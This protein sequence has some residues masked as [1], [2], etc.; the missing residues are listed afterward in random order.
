MI[1]VTRDGHVMTLEM[2]REEVLP[3]MVTAFGI[4]DPA[5]ARANKSTRKG[6][7]PLL[8][9]ARWYKPY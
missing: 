4:E 5:E 3:F 6:R 8:C 2:R 7:V 1:G 9:A